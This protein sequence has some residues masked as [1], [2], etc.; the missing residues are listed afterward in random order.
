M[1][2]PFSPDYAHRSGFILR[3]RVLVALSDAVVVAQAGLRSG[4]LHAAGCALRLG[5][6]LWV[7][8]APP[9]RDAGFEG[10]HELVDAIGRDP[11]RP[12]RSP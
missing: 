5:K 2:W 1:L 6:P 8:P 10:T 4:A 11:T 3:N 9:W 7:V 12:I